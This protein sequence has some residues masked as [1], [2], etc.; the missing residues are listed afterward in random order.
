ML[1]WELMEMQ[2]LR[3]L[4][5]A[6]LAVRI[7]DAEFLVVATASRPAVVQGVAVRVLR[8]VLTHFLGEARPRDIALRIVTAM[9]DGEAVVRP[10][11]PEEIEAAERAAPTP[12]SSSFAPDE[13]SARAGSDA[14]ALKGEPLLTFDGRRL[15]V[16]FRTDPVIDLARMAPAGHRMEP[17][18]LYESSGVALTAVERRQLMP[19]DMER[20]NLAAFDRMASRL[21]DMAERRS[22]ILCVS[23]LTITNMRARARL[24]QKAQP[25][26][27][28]MR[29]SVIWELTDVEEGA[30]VGRL[31][32]VFT[33]LKPFGR[34]TF[35]R[36]SSGAAQKA[37]Q[38]SGAPGLVAQPPAHTMEARDAAVWLLQAGKALKKAAPTLVAADLPSIEVLP[39]AAAA[40]FT[41]AAV[42]TQASA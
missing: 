3:R 2:L 15:R 21:V 10:V 1:V 38:V 36:A 34:T 13:T 29:A 19:G 25:F 8:D 7:G 22:I 17:L 12:E 11:A 9:Q 4:P 41:H 40:G 33:L 14:D 27:E 16:S 24:F 37:A 5:P 35:L 20:V 32:E 39:V 26:R 42:R 6:D 18:M 31:M 30:P 23:F 28:A